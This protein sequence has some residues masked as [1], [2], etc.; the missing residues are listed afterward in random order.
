[1]RFKFPQGIRLLHFLIKRF[2]GVSNCAYHTLNSVTDD[3]SGIALHS[4]TLWPE[5]RIVMRFILPFS[6]QAAN[7]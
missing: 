6:W 5:Q 7:V 2:C 4:Y 1:M 3:Y